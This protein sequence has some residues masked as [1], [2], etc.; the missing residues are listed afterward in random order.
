VSAV[1]IAALLAAVSI[2]LP[3]VAD[4]RVVADVDYLATADHGG[5]DRLD[6]YAPADAK[7]A[8]VV[9]SIHGGA[10][11]QGDRK[12]EV[13]V[14]RRF[15]AAGFVT[16]VPS[17]RLS[18]GVS[19][20]AHI[21]DVAAAFAWVKAHIAQHGGDPERIFV[22]GHSAGA[23]LAALL[24]TDTRYLAAHKLSPRD[25][26]GIVPVSGFFWVDRTG[27]AP[28]RPKHVW[29]TDAAVWRDASPSRHLKG[30]IPPVLL[31]YADGDEAWRRAQNVEMADALRA[32]GVRDLDLREVKNRTHMSIWMKMAEGAAEDTSSR[33]VEFV[34]RLA[35]P[36]SSR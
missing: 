4:V 20:P 5:K 35:Q 19:H 1:T 36:T 18:P 30:V 7:R 14:G 3:A 34:N 22:I 2:A 25:I 12:E 17:Y 15:A 21:E 28:D 32:S 16:V 33:I 8:P 24:A 23:Y 9:V 13:F 11:S 6:I 29:G 26:K 10:L 27:V 31:I